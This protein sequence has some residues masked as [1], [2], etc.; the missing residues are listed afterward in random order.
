MKPAAELMGDSPTSG[1]IDPVGT[2]AGKDIEQPTIIR[3]ALPDQIRIAES[4]INPPAPN[5]RLRRAFALRES[6]IAKGG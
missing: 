6:L 4:L 1:I 5:E 2:L 3:L